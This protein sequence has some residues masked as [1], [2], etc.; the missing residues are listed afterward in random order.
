MP[1]KERLI[2][3]SE[4]ARQLCREQLRQTIDAAVN[5]LLEIGWEPEMVAV[6]LLELADNYMD[7]VMDGLPIREPSVLL[8]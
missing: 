6:A 1:G 8:H 7:A 4:H 2:G 5:E 3:F